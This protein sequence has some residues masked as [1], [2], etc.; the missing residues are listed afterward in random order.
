MLANHIIRQFLTQFIGLVSGFVISIITARILGPENRGEFS[1]LLNTSGFLC[2]LFGFSYGTSMVYIIANNKMPLRNA[3]NSFGLLVLILIAICFITLFFFPA[4]WYHF[5][6]PKSGD[7]TYY[8]WILFALFALTVTG[9]LYNSVLSGKKLFKEQQLSFL[10]TST[11]SII[12]YIIVFIYRKEL[13]INVQ[14]F[15]L[16]YLLLAVLP[17]L[18]Y[19]LIYLKKTRPA[20]GFRFLD[21]GQM[22]YV[23]GFS[24]MAYLCTIFHFLS[25]RIDFWIVEYYNGSK[26]LGIYS[27]AVNLAQMIWILPQAISVILLSYSGDEN[28][29]KSNDNTNTLSRVALAII[30]LAAVFL[31][32][33][34]DF[35][36]PLLFG[37]AYTDSA[38]LFKMLLFGIVPF[39]LTTIL[40]SY[41]AGSGQVK[42]N[43]YCSFLGFLSCL[44]LDLLLIPKFGTPGAA[45]A[46]GISYIISTTFIVLMYLKTTHT[47]LSA[48]VMFR[49]QDLN[50]IRHKVKQLT[51][52]K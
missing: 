50:L 38:F 40:S 13:D 39:S 15:S 1:M 12:A 7:A 20:M 9:I 10:I 22:K 28:K 41:F 34:I 36:M 24:L 4:S 5:I 14:K 8:L 11:I 49:K 26:D 18:G 23:L 35:F 48:L 46:S 6:V 44:I 17:N 25:C 30:F 52:R 37:E 21:A 51:G 33:T 29:Q 31:F 32:F 2:L 27:L 43:L 19:Y 16:F 42:V 45:I 47:R 3:I